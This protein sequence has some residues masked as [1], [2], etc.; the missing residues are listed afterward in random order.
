M[1]RGFSVY[2]DLL[3][4]SA[5]CAVFLSHASFIRFS[6]GALRMPEHLAHE[7]VIVFFVLSGYVICYV[8]HQRENRLPV[9]FISRAARIY[10]VAIP[11]LLLTFLIDV[12][13]TQVGAGVEVRLY[14]MLAP[15]KYVPVF[16]TFTTDIW[17]LR[18]NAFSNAPYWSLCYEVWYYV[19][20]ASLFFLGGRW[21]LLALVAVAAIVGPRL[22]LLFPIWLAGAA[23]Y[24]LSGR[25]CFSP[26]AARAWFIVSGLAIIAVWT[27]GVDANIDRSVN[28]ASGGWIAANLRYSQYFMGDWLTGALLALNLLAAGHLDLRFGVLTR[29]IVWCAGFSFTLYLVHYPLLE[30]FATFHPSA[31]LLLTAVLL[32]TFLIGLVTERQKEQIRRALRLWLLPADIAVPPV[33][34]YAAAAT[35][36]EAPQHDNPS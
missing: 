25:E 4:L 13:L 18:E 1:R 10:S 3:R 9:Y 6:H 15:W 31:P 11:A 20:F 27:L 30:F 16:L 7:A 33:A 14:Q 24:K 19:A 12:Y 32:A 26:R 22:W 2:L 34:P 17:F 29:P 28:V 21:R 5:A 35:L 8:A 23:T 36:R